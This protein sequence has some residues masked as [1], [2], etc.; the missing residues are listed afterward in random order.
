M[1]IG[2][3]IAL[4]LLIAIAQSQS[5]S[6]SSQSSQSSSSSSSQSSHSSSDL[7][8][9]KE[10]TCVNFEDF[11]HTQVVDRVGDFI[12]VSGSAPVAVF[13]GGVPATYTSGDKIYG[14]PLNNYQG[15]LPA[16]GGLSDGAD[17]D[18]RQYQF[19]FTFDTPVSGFSFSTYDFGDLNEYQVDFDQLYAHSTSIDGSPAGND[20]IYEVY[21]NDQNYAGKSYDACNG[22]AKNFV[23]NSDLGTNQIKTVE[24]YLGR[25][26]GG[27]AP[28]TLS[29]PS[30]TNFAFSD[31]CYEILSCES[32]CPT[33]PTEVNG[34]TS[35]SWCEKLE[36]SG[37]YYYSNFLRNI[38]GESDA[39]SSGLDFE[40]AQ[41]ILCGHD[42]ENQLK[43]ELL[44]TYLNIYSKQLFS[45]FTLNQLC[46]N[47]DDEEEDH[48]ES[49]DDHSEDHGESSDNKE[50]HND[51]SEASHGDHE[52]SHNDHTE[53]SNGG[54]NYNGGGDN[55]NGGND[56]SE[57]SSHA[58][59]TKSSHADHT[60]GHSSSKNWK[61]DNSEEDHG[62]NH[63]DHEE[64]SGESSNGSG[65]SRLNSNSTIRSVIAAAEAAIVEGSK[66]KVTQ[67]LRHTLAT[68]N[69]ATAPGIGSCPSSCS[70]PTQS[71][72]TGSSTNQTGSSHTN[73]TNQQP[74]V[75]PT[76]HTNQK[77]PAD[78]KEEDD[79]ELTGDDNEEDQDEN[80]DDD[81]DNEVD[82]TPKKCFVKFNFTTSD[83]GI[84]HGKL[85]ALLEKLHGDYELVLTISGGGYENSKRVTQISGV[86]EI[87]TVDEES[88]TLAA[89]AVH[90][91]NDTDIS[92]SILS[93]TL[94]AVNENGEVFINNEKPKVDTQVEKVS[95]AA[96]VIGVFAVVVACVSIFV[97]LK[98]TFSKTTKIG[99]TEAS[100]NPEV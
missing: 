68:I 55:N 12:T 74:P 27:S 45:D 57:K 87:K 56:H 20:I 17:K 3:L 79:N 43:K 61:R 9:K 72:Q 86:A 66:P 77:P 2:W 1:R 8:C 47:D 63:D 33:T 64:D 83:L 14:H 48:E 4:A 5:S 84:F 23:V 34:T 32:S 58:E 98:H 44:T 89:K 91:T 49:H 29:G 95:V 40:T 65:C 46:C 75:V 28:V 35:S 69:N 19:T 88:A 13:P 6:S 39:F 81:D 25:T 96:I 80:G 24:I 10:K 59:S 52:E 67:N 99:A 73:Q 92:S 16:T 82:F 62:E 93:D 38:S 70:Q 94:T 76:N 18:N 85:K 51:H 54:D 36:S 90:R 11:G 21:Y 7:V 26:S 60:E 97:V 100:R 41:E 78:D 50:S 53:S 42:H 37:R 30:D 22:G 31:F 71:N 15:C